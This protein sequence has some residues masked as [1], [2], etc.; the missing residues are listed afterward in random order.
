[1]LSKTEHPFLLVLLSDQLKHILR[2]LAG[3]RNPL[4]GQRMNEAQFFGMQ[5][6]PV[7]KLGFFL[8]VKPIAAQRMSYRRHVQAYLVRSPGFRNASNKRK[9]SGFP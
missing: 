1:M 6:R 5:C 9:L 4:V 7:D 8:S 2:K 3:Q